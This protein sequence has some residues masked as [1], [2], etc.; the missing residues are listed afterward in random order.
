[1][2]YGLLKDG[3]LGF[4]QLIKILPLL[5]LLKILYSQIWGLGEIFQKEG[6]W[7]RILVILFTW[8]F[9][10]KTNLFTLGLFIIGHFGRP[11]KTFWY[12]A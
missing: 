1:L 11:G 7:V 10:G 12:W 3:F 6:S 8:L 2:D 9:Q 4:F 5:P